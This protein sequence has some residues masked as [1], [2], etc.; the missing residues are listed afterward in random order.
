MESFQQLIIEAKR[1]YET[2]D[3]LAFVTYPMIKEPKLIIT[4]ITHINNALQ[5]A[6]QALL[7]YERLYKRISYIPGEFMTKIYMLRQSIFPRYQMQDYSN[8]II[9]VKNIVN[10]HKSSNMEFIKRD[11]YFIYSNSYSNVA[12]IN[13][14]NIKDY[15]DKTRDFVD[16]VA[17]VMEHGRTPR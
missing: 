2:A 4:I 10:S 12:S 16:K 17:L 15:I 6:S 14:N 13:M 3:H 1:A 11:K 5:N 9:E 7:E 8:L